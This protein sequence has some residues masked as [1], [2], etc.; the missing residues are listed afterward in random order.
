MDPVGFGVSVGDIVALVQ[1]AAEIYSSFKEIHNTTAYDNVKRLEQELSILSSVLNKFRT[2]IEVSDGGEK[3]HEQGDRIPAAMREELQML[4]RESHS[5]LERLKRH[6]NRAENERPTLH[7]IWLGLL[8]TNTENLTQRWNRFVQFLL[9]SSGSHIILTNM[10]RSLLRMEIASWAAS[11][12]RPS[13]PFWIGGGWC[14]PTEPEFAVI[15]SKSLSDIQ[16]GDILLDR[17][18]APEGA[19]DVDAEAG[20]LEQHRRHEG[21]RQNHLIAVMGVTGAGKST[22]IRAVQREHESEALQFGSSGIRGYWTL[23]VLKRLLHALPE[24]LPQPRDGGALRAA[25]L[26]G[27]LDIFRLLVAAGA[28]IDASDSLRICDHRIKYGSPATYQGIRMKETYP[29]TIHPT[30]KSS[31]KLFDLNL[32]WVSEENGRLDSPLFSARRLQRIIRTSFSNCTM[33]AP[34]ALISS[35]CALCMHNYDANR[36]AQPAG[37]LMRP[38]PIWSLIDNPSPPMLVAATM[39]HG[40]ATLAYYALLPGDRFRESF[41][42]IALVSAGAAGYGIGADTESVLIGILPLVIT[43]SLLVCTLM[44]LLLKG[45][46]VGS[47]FEEGRERD[48][49]KQSG[50]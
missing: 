30:N 27:N 15:D 8:A 11:S 29:D 12:V 19:A 46:G 3:H 28:K 16:L 23:L 6:V 21:D 37:H 26:Q 45:C 48:L 39:T 31:R 4:V 49:E 35:A 10:C 9:W 5:T 36:H 13:E 22:F 50:T 34:A 2:L 1:L 24:K 38:I 43:M 7:K 32:G 44:N 18:H 47:S 40:I 42:G 17:E 20:P 25:S 14:V 33:A 41:L